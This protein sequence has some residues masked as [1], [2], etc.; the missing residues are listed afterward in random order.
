MNSGRKKNKGPKQHPGPW[1]SQL[2]DHLEEI[3]RLR[4]A[5][6][7]WKDIAKALEAQNVTITASALRNFFVRSRDPKL[8]LPAGLE[9]L[10]PPESPS[11]ATP[12]NSPPYHDTPEKDADPLSTDVREVPEDDPFYKFNKKQKQQSP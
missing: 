11:P 5:R 4:R 10:R 7:K 9:H 3:R 8:K 6:T 1:G 12:P 2:W